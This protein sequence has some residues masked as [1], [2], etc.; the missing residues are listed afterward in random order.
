MKRSK[1]W[2]RALEFLFSESFDDSEISKKY[3]SE[4]SY[5]IWGISEYINI[6]SFR[7]ESTFY[8]NEK[9][10]LEFFNINLYP[11]IGS[12]KISL[13]MFT[14]NL[15][16]N[17]NIT[18]AA[19][20]RKTSWKAV[21]CDIAVYT[22]PANTRIVVRNCVFSNI[23]I[24]VYGDGGSSRLISYYEVSGCYI[25]INTLGTGGSTSVRPTVNINNSVLA[26]I[27]N[28]P[29][30]DASD[31]TNNVNNVYCIG[32][33]MVECVG[34]YLYSGVHKF[35]SSSTNG[36]DKVAFRS[37]YVKGTPWLFIGADTNPLKCAEVTENFFDTP[38]TDLA[39][40]GCV[41]FGSYSSAVVG[42]DSIGSMRI[43]GNYF[44]NVPY[45]VYYI[46]LTASN[47]IGD[48]NIVG[49]RYSNT[50][51]GS[52]GNYA[53]VN[54]N[55]AG[56][57]Y[58]VLQCANEDVYGNSNT[59]SY[60]TSGN[61]FSNTLLTNINETGIT[62]TKTGFTSGSFTATLT[63]CTTSPTTTIYYTIRD[64]VVVMHIASINATSNSINCTLTGLPS[65]LQPNVLTYFC[66]VAISDN[67]AYSNNAQAS[68]AAGS[69]TIT[70]YKN[71]SLNGF[72]NSG[73]KGIYAST[74]TYMLA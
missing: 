36:V 22:M 72:T 38:V 47:S 45:N 11:S 31:R 6:Q 1:L 62:G 33:Q 42:S 9:S 37:N 54:Y 26:V 32:T 40:Y 58:R 53:V 60:L 73:T 52:S 71:G 30:L 23:D 41:L 10:L 70:L 64:S 24:G 4:D 68:I 28:N 29:M 57:A 25:T 7:Y 14:S 16:D 56:S 2:F 43:S 12:D 69:G 59:K 20:A 50:S 13:I 55:V 61:P 34:N 48:V 21:N 46:A 15:F 51:T 18:V 3:I 39:S 19:V 35:V 5:K 8:K 66:P 17:L 63:G 65:I 49:N 67:S 74:I 44:L 27:K